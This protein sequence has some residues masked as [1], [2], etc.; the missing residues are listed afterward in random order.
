VRNGTATDIGG[1]ILC[2]GLVEMSWLGPIDINGNVAGNNG[3]GV[4]L[5]GGCRLDAATVGRSGGGGTVRIRYNDAGLAAGGMYLTDVNFNG[6]AGVTAATLRGGS[7][8]PVS[9]FANT[10]RV[11]GGAY[12]S[13]FGGLGAT[14]LTTY[15]TRF[16]SNTATTAGGALYLFGDSIATIDRNVSVCHSA[17]FCSTLSWNQALGTQPFPLGF[18]Q[19]PTGQGGAVFL[20]G[21]ANLVL[22]QTRIDHSQ[23]GNGASVLIAQGLGG[24][25]D[26][27]GVVLHANQDS[28]AG[29]LLTL[30]G[31]GASMRLAHVS[32]AANLTTNTGRMVAGGVVEIYSSVFG[33]SWPQ[34]IGN[35]A[36]GSKI[37]CSF[38]PSLALLPIVPTRSAVANNPSLL[39]MDSVNGNLHL[40]ASSPAIDYCDTSSYIPV[41]RDIDHQ[42][43]G[44]DH[45]QADT[46]GP[47]DIGA[48]EVIP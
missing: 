2:E 4:A 5:M 9:I 31:N 29:A 6:P 35:V 27:E 3:G 16:S 24:Q 41:D 1:G 18:P 36:G 39:F 47:Y 10:A 14:Q 23:S 42:T 21:P 37:D 28:G 11:G 22:R 43:R 15:N 48:D 7:T 32:S 12:L 45:P 34:V 44:V 46:Y 40:T 30:A 26:A 20:D 8:N 19:Y 25:V 38:F 33:E 17:D 13:N